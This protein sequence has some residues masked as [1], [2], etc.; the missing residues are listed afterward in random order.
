M[1]YY[2]DTGCKDFVIKKEMDLRNKVSF[3]NVFYIIF[4]LLIDSCDAPFDNS[5]DPEN[6][7]HTHCFFL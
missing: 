5:L 3:V 4:I 7:D 1:L 6:M 2:I